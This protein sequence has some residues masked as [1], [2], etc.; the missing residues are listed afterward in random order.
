MPLKETKPNLIRLTKVRP[1][2][3]TSRSWNLKFFFLKCRGEFGDVKT[4]FKIKKTFCF[5]ENFSLLVSEV[6]FNDFVKN[7]HFSKFFPIKAFLAKF[8]MLFSNSA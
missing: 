7:L 6:N 2:Q 5:H 4:I 1:G 8:S 3:K